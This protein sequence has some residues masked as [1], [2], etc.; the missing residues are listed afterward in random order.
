MNEGN[1]RFL[2]TEKLTVAYA[3]RDS[4]YSF[5]VE[6]VPPCAINKCDEQDLKQ[7]SR[8]VLLKATEGWLTEK[9]PAVVTGITVKTRL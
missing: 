6:R 3:K 5:D 8:S 1:S 7:R 9:D 4:H 2:T